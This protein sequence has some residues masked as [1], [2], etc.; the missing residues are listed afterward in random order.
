MAALTPKIG[1][2]KKFL[3]FGE[4]GKLDENK[5]I[6]AIQDQYDFENAWRAPAGKVTELMEG[7]VD[8]ERY[9]FEAAI[10]DFDDEY[11]ENWY[12]E[13]MAHYGVDCA[14]TF[15]EEHM[16]GYIQHMS[17][18]YGLDGAETRKLLVFDGGVDWR[19]LPAFAEYGLRF[20]DQV[21]S[22]CEENDDI[23]NPH[24]KA[25]TAKLRAEERA[26][27]RQEAKRAKTN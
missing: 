21:V 22:V 9:A 23:E 1:F 11:L 18:N 8:L 24:D 15:V 10:S 6:A 25:A 16:Y 27:R 12:Y 7:I 19:D 17:D 2:G 20:L 13:R 4:D 5:T 26:A 3:R 14:Q